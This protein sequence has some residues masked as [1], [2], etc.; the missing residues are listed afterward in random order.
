MLIELNSLG[1]LTISPFAVFKNFVIII[2]G[3]SFHCE[4]T[5]TQI[6]TIVLLCKGLLWAYEE[7]K[8]FEANEFGK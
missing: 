1:S 2:G 7:S 6:T 8:F 4:T 3:L 5:P